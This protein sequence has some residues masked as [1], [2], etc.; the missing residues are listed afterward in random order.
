MSRRF[1]A[2]MPDAM[3]GRGAMARQEGQS[4]DIRLPDVDHQAGSAP[5]HGRQV[6]RQCHSVYQDKHWTFDEARYKQMVEAQVPTTLCPGCDQQFNGNYEGRLLLKS[7]LIAE[8]KQQA[9]GIIRHEEQRAQSVN[10]NARVVALMDRGNELEVW[11]STYFLA[12]RIGQEF[13]KA[14]KGKLI[15][16]KLPRVRF[17][18]LTWSRE[19]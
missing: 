6:C 10:P 3:K 9:L 12:H 16:H 17:S 4:L 5:P 2:K 8:N 18:R 11:T 7:P 15:E 1:S 14:W 13:Q 19:E